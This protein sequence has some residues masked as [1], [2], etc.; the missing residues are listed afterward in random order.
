MNIKN[1]EVECLAGEVAS[2]T[3]ESK[4][5]TVRRALQER[6]ERLVLDAGDPGARASR[7][8]RLLEQEIWPQVPP[9]ELGGAP[10]DRA[11]RESLLGYGPDGV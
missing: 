7:L 5:E 2:L 11:E 10:L 8:L 3:G 9:G 6:R 4:T 1:A